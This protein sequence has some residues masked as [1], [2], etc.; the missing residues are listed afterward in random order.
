MSDATYLCINVLDKHDLVNFFGAEVAGLFDSEVTATDQLQAEGLKKR[1]KTMSAF[2][3]W[4]WFK[5]RMGKLLDLTGHESLRFLAGQAHTH[6]YIH[7]M[8]EDLPGLEYE[9]KTQCEYSLFKDDFTP[10]IRALNDLTA[11]CKSNPDQAGEIVEM[12]REDTLN[13]IEYA[14]FT[15]DP[16]SEAPSSDEGEGGDFFFCTLKTIGD[17]FRYAH[18][19]KNMWIVYENSQVIS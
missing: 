2:T 12:Y 16:K 14:F 5:D 8:K 17:L 7:V 10:V 18:S 15:L 3:R 1:R 19:G 11:W 9:I 4:G 6:K 13:A